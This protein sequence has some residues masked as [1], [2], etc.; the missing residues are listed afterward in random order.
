MPKLRE[1][2]W[3]TSCSESCLAQ[4]FRHGGHGLGGNSAGNDQ[5]EVVEIGVHIEG[6]AVRG[7]GAGDVD[8]DGGDFGF[9]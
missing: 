3:A 9:V 6:E 1:M 8:A 5:V 7:D 4:F 2:E